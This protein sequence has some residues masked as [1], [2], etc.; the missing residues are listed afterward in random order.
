MPIAWLALRPECGV[1]LFLK[2]VFEDNSRVVESDRLGNL[3]FIELNLDVFTVVSYVYMVSP[4]AS[5]K[6]SYERIEKELS[7]KP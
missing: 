6:S 3:F 1:D 5:E 2:T 7:L 4:L